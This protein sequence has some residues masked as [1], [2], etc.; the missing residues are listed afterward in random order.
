MTKKAV[1]VETLSGL[2]KISQK[3]LSR[4]YFG[5]ETC[6]RKLPSLQELEKAKAACKKNDLA[7][8]LMT[9]FATDAGIERIKPL[10]K[11]LSPEDELIVNDF[12]VLQLAS[13]TKAEP[14]CG[15]LLNKQFRD[16]RI[17]SFQASNEMLEHLS[18]SQASTKGFRKT[19]SEFGVKRVEL[20]N[21]LQGIATSLSQT[22]FSASLYTP[23][24]FIS[25][26][27]MCLACNSKKL[28]DYKKIGVL[29]C[30]K[31][32]LSTHF[33]QTNKAFPRPL[34]VFGNALFFENP[35]LPNQESLEEKG[36]NRLVCNNSLK[37]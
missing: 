6:E 22:G 20:D 14:V 26:T 17:A 21:L 27:R 7:F 5:P 28:S 37:L 3:G 23:F 2:E 11:A 32:C 13:Q 29:N 4:L 24:V 25:A 8:S 36:I 31:E 15:R 19:L 34:L 10:L 33:E 30:G 12:G 9:P 35:S 16:P 1:A 18:L